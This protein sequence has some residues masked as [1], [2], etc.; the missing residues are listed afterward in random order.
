MKTINKI[1]MAIAVIIL[2]PTVMLV[3]FILIAD[4]TDMDLQSI[5]WET[6]TETETELLAEVES[7]GG[8][9]AETAP[10]AAVPPEG[11]AANENA[12][13][14]EAPSDDRNLAANPPASWIPAANNG[15]IQQQ[16]NMD[17]WNANQSSGTGSGSNGTISGDTQTQTENM[18]EA[19]Q[20]L[21][22][23]LDVIY[24]NDPNTYIDL[25]IGTAEEAAELYEETLDEETI[26]DLLDNLGFAEVQADERM[27]LI[28]QI[29]SNVR[30][31]VGEA[32]KQNDGS[33][34]VTVAY[35]KM[36]IYMPTVD[37]YIKKAESM[38]A[39]WNRAGSEGGELPSYEIMNEQ[40]IETYTECLRESLGNITYEKSQNV[41]VRL[42][43]VNKAYEINDE[44]ITKFGNLLT[45]SDA[46]VEKLDKAMN[47]WEF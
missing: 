24:K 46:A 9:N 4:A 47:K 33:Y 25:K 26:N 1:F 44:D 6:G 39:G 14:A 10:D 35:E 17:A 16:L 22:A 42:K 23:I 12:G 18:P 41:T 32:K 19:A 38:I 45:D 21:K 43:V 5:I 37:A 13:E 8:E 31:N 15:A 27:G 3:A 2:T 29:L 34:V 7:A 28:K 11:E 30:Y 40:L 36:N 20:Y